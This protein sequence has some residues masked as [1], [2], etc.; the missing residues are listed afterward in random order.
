MKTPEGPVVKKSRLHYPGGRM[1][2]KGRKTALIAGL[3]LVVV[4]ALGAA[5]WKD[6]L[7]RYHLYRL[8]KDPAHLLDIAGAPPGTAKGMAVDAFLVTERGARAA[9]NGLIRRTLQTC[10]RGGRNARYGLQDFLRF[11]NL[12][13]GAGV[14][15]LARREGLLGLFWEFGP[16]EGWSRE[17][18]DESN[19]VLKL[20][21]RVPK[22]EI[23]LPEHP[24]VA[25]SVLTGEEARRLFKSDTL[26]T[27]FEPGTRLC[28]FR[29]IAS[30]SP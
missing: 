16:L 11:M 29:T 27:E 25:I 20:L 3:G 22:A 28:I 4:L 5:Y 18:M 19:S 23:R 30:G 6:L 14:I 8:E 17:T 2:K 15:G 24:P 1:S 21:Y 9:V 13:S 7:F 10:N 26:F 12:K